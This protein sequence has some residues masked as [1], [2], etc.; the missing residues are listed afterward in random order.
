MITRKLSTSLTMIAV[1]ALAFSSFQ[2]AAESI[3]TTTPV[4]V[5]EESI[6]LSYSSEQGVLRV[7]YWADEKECQLALSSIQRMGLLIEV[8]GAEVS[9][10]LKFLEEGEVWPKAEALR[11]EMYTLRSK[12]EFPGWVVVVVQRSE[13]GGEMR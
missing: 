2:S 1:C 9:F 10:S 11:E 3:T 4:S 13:Q 8:V 6:N 12:F 7:T 5:G